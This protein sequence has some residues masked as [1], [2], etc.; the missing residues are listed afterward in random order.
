MSSSNHT[1]AAVISEDRWLTGQE[2]LQSVPSCA[3]LPTKWKSAMTL[4]SMKLLAKRCNCPSRWQNVRTKTEMARLIDGKVV[5]SNKFLETVRHFTFDNYVTMGVSNLRFFLSSSLSKTRRKLND[6]TKENYNNQRTLLFESVIKP[7]VEAAVHIVPS[8]SG[9]HIGYGYILTCAHCVVH[10]DVDDDD[11]AKNKVGRIVELV[12]ARGKAFGAIC[13]MACDK[14]DLA[15]LHIPSS[16]SSFD[17]CSITRLELGCLKVGPKGSD[18]NGTKIFAIGNPCDTDLETK[19]KNKSTGFFPF[20]VSEGNLVTKVSEEIASKDGL[21]R[22]IHNAWTYWGHSGCPLVTTIDNFG[23]CIVGLHNS[24]DDRNGNRHGITL[25]E[26]S[27]FVRGAS[28]ELPSCYRLKCEHNCDEILEGCSKKRSSYFL[29][30][31]N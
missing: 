28:V 25:D 24:W 11:P 7:A 21:G 13:V 6:T 26:I 12:T 14:T 23:P 4:K 9:A 18:S 10:D 5:E 8:G 16:S 27:L 3:D 2:K 17:D 31:R 20:H 30:P 29:R 15:L 19:V 1:S 22:Q